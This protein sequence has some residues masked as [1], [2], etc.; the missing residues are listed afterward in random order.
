MLEMRVVVG[1]VIAGGLAT[2]CGASGDPP[3]AAS[4]SSGG[5][6]EDAGDETYG[7]RE[8]PPPDTL[9]FRVPAEGAPVRGAER[10][11]VT[12]VVFSDFQCPFCARAAHTLDRLLRAHP[13]EVRLVFR[14]H[15]LPLHDRALPAA[16]VAEEAWQQG[17]DEAFWAMHDALFGRQS[18]LGQDALLDRA[19]GLG[20]DVEGVRAALE[21]HRHV[22]RIREDQSIALALGAEGAPAHFL[23]GRPIVGAVPYRDLEPIVRQEIAL[24]EQLVAEGTPREALYATLQRSAIAP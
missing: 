18:A 5:E 24:A 6:T 20:L 13:D 19:R 11:L 22:P 14:H 23:N 16:E 2:G 7:H 8:L 12:I 4:A 10:P 21:D 3:T 1:L 15:P 17:G 9:R